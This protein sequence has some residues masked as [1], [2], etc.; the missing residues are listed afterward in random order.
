MALALGTSSAEVGQAA[1]EMEV[2]GSALHV[3]HEPLT[4]ALA[5]S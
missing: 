1:A 2:T 3:T 4:Q 5:A